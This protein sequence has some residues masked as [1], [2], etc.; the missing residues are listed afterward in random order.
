MG[1]CGGAIQQLRQPPTT[2]GVPRRP[3]RLNN[4]EPTPALALVRGGRIDI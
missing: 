1:P 4:E 3:S 2:R